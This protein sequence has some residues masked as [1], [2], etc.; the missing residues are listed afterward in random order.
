MFHRIGVIMEPRKSL[1]LKKELPLYANYLSNKEPEC[2]IDQDKR[3][4]IRKLPWQS[5]ATQR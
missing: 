5:R 2:N 3:L 1:L 4:T